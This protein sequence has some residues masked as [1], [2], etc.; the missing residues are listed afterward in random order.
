LSEN[1]QVEVDFV[2][3]NPKMVALAEH[4]VARM[5]HVFRHRVRFF[6]GDVRE[7][8]PRAAGYDLIVMH[9]FLDCFT[10]A[11]LK[12]LVALVAPS[13]KSETIQRASSAAQR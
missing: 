9:F 10:E 1:G 3:L 6:V 7:F 4:R 5:G 11:Q 13:A 8:E 2:E 12:E